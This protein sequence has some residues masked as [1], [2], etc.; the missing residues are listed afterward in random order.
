[1]QL[2]RSLYIQENTISVFLANS[3]SDFVSKT[4]AIFDNNSTS[5]AMR[6]KVINR[7]NKKNVCKKF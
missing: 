6:P 7:I 1:M 3:E 2:S 4:S 5:V